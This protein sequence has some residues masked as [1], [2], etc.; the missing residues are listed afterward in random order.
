MYNPNGTSINLIDKNGKI[1]DIVEASEQLNLSSID[2]AIQKH[3]ICFP[4]KRD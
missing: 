1:E 3:F 4:K 2:Q